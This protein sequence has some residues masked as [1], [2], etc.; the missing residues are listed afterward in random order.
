MRSVVIGLTL[1]GAATA[2]RADEH[3]L[4]RLLVAADYGAIERSFTP[5]MTKAVPPGTLAK[6]F[7]GLR[8]ERG[9]VTDCKVAAPGLLRCSVEKP[10]R[11]ELHVT[12]AGAQ[13]T[14]LRLN[15]EVEARELPPA[16]TRLRPPFSGTFTAMNANRD[17][18]NGHFRNRNQRHAVDWL[19]MDE[20]GKTHSGDPK[21]LQSYYAY[22]KPA[23]AVAAGKVVMVVDGVPE[24]APGKKDAYNITGN[25]VAIELAPSEIAFYAH[26]QPG[27]IRVKVGELVAAGQVVGLIG[28]SG[29]TSEPHLHFQISTQPAL[30]D[31]ESMPAQYPGAFLDGKRVERAWPSTG[32]RLSFDAPQD[33]KDVVQPKEKR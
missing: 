31:A 23:L 10:P 21:R 32:Q 30:T 27:S 28:N 4:G 18:A 19:I 8:R 29:N 1:V 6:L 5:D 17:E 20:A 25:Q 22:G 16:K 26:L 7:D 33:G 13:V 11:I 9:K 12:F 24:Q 2:A 3:E 15:D 14:G